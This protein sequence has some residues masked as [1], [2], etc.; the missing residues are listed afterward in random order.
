MSA[1]WLSYAESRAFSFMIPNAIV[2]KTS[3]ADTVQ[4]NCLGSFLDFSSQ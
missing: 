3:K 4:V 1:S 2:I